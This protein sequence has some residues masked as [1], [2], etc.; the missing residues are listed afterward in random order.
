MVMIMDD[1]E[2]ILT[3]EGN[4]GEGY[5]LRIII[6]DGKWKQQNLEDAMFVIVCI[7]KTHPFIYFPSINFVLQF[8]EIVQIF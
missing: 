4:P 6:M 8:I 2:R 5:K 1:E 7:Q 3:S